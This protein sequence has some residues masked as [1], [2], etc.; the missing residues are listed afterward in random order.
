MLMLSQTEYERC[1]IFEIGPF[2]KLTQVS[3]ITQLT[4]QQYTNKVTENC[5]AFWNC[6]GGYK[7]EEAEAIDELIETPK[8]K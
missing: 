8:S 5:I 7:Q 2:E 6:N 4:G 3:F 1:L